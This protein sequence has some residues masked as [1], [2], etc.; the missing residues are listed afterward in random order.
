VELDLTT[1]AT[2]RTFAMPAGV[3]DLSF[4]STG[5]LWTLSEAGSRKWSKWATHYPLVIRIDVSKLR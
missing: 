3:E 4:D 2:Q 5:A 1:G